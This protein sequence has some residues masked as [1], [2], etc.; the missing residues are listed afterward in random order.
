MS[1]THS[2]SQFCL[3]RRNKDGMGEAR[4]SGSRS[5]EASAR[6]FM[7]GGRTLRCGGQRFEAD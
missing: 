6:S 7:A 2:M 3:A 5:T 1:V 4:E